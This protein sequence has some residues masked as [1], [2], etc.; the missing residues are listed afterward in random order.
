MQDIMSDSASALASTG[1]TEFAVEPELLASRESWVRTGNITVVNT[2]VPT[3]ALV[4]PRQNFTERKNRFAFVPDGYL[5]F[6]I[7]W[8]HLDG[9]RRGLYRMTVRTEAVGPT[10]QQGNDRAGQTRGADSPRRAI[11]AI[12]SESRDESG[13]PVISVQA[14]CPI[15]ATTEL[16]LALRRAS[17]KQSA[18]L[19]APPP[20]L[21]WMADASLLAIGTYLEP[22]LL[23]N[24]LTD[25]PESGSGESPSSRSPSKRQRSPSKRA[26]RHGG[27]GP[28]SSDQGSNPVLA[29]GLWN[30]GQVSGTLR[31]TARRLH[32]MADASDPEWF[33][34]FD[35][36]G[37]L[38][39]AA[40]A[41]F[42]RH[43]RYIMGV[44]QEQGQEVVEQPPPWKAV[45][46]D[47]ALSVG[48]DHLAAE[49]RICEAGRLAGMPSSR[50]TKK[51]RRRSP[52]QEEVSSRTKADLISKVRDM[53]RDSA[54]QTLQD[55]ARGTGAF[56]RSTASGSAP[57][58]GASSFSSSA[59]S[60]GPATSLQLT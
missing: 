2:G 50:G 27:D 15:G 58:A 46:A 54:I 40:L 56:A 26:A 48:L 8:S 6:A 38:R 16:V 43:A 55:L 37:L 34:G 51:K 30:L 52:K 24:A 60:S 33:A 23:Q 32:R 39:S 45:T 53:K 47:D 22:I 18:V 17:T 59:S 25:D 1:S 3:L 7:F 13:H 11:F 57:G 9:G 19:G 12:D 5:A 36:M 44:P 21:P 35:L 49:M 4:S 42:R 41:D 10:G 29:A 28:R 31:D 14:G 20:P